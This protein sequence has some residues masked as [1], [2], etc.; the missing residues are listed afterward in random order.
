VRVEEPA[1]QSQGQCHLRA[2]HRDASA[3]MF[4]LAHSALGVASTADAESLGGALQSRSPSHGLGARRS[5][6]SSGSIDTIIEV[7]ASTRRLSFRACQ[8]NTRRTA[9]RVFAPTCVKRIGVSRTSAGHSLLAAGSRGI[10]AEHSTGV[11]RNGG[12][13]TRFVLYLRSFAG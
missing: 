8:S 2:R 10:N 4:G 13:A 7:A 9:P 11:A 3:R 5:R 12:G 1:A 6:S